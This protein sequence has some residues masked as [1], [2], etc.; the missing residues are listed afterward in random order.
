[1][2][3]AAV[4]QTRVEEVTLSEDRAHVVRRGKAM[5]PAGVGQLVVEGVAPVLADKTLRV[6]VAGARVGVVKVERRRELV[7]PEQKARTEVQALDAELEKLGR[8]AG[9]LAAQ[10]RRLETEVGLA[11]EG[12][13]RVLA[14]LAEDAARGDLPADA[15]RLAAAFE[16][17][18]KRARAAL[19]EARETSGDVVDTLARLRARRAAKGAERSETR[20]SVLVTVSA[21]R[22]GEADV[23]V[24]YVVPGACW[25]P[26]HTA[27][28]GERVRVETDA[29]VWQ[30]TG[31]AWEDVR[32][33]VS[34]ERPSLGTSPPRL[35]DDR[36]QV[37]RKAEVLR[38][39][40]RDQD[41]QTAG[42][43]GRAR[44]P[45]IDDGGEVRVIEAARR[46]TVPSDGRPHRVRLG[47]FDA[48]VTTSVVAMPEIAA[49][50][51]LRGVTS[52]AGTLPVLAGPVDLVRGGGFAGRAK[53]GFVA[54]GERFEL[55]WGPD[56]HL[57]VRRE[58]SAVDEEPGL[59]PSS[60]IGRRHEVRVTLS[61]LDSTPRS[62]EVVERVPVSEV[63]KVQIDVDEKHTSPR[64]RPDA[65]G[66]VRW[67]VELPPRGH[68]EIA[69][70]YVV[71]RHKDVAG[72]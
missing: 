27:I 11:E 17:G 55:G 46:A 68:A 57:R 63:E 43:G 16:A 38:V 4:A 34:T 24:E 62:V 59:L 12:A 19:V 54:P 20:A 49:A 48:D 67:T 36:L 39:E 15:S 72:V 53:V 13:R 69:L 35:A 50:A 65:D 31:E 52:N 25:R 37:Q 30:A 7:I 2:S 9:M 70:C 26:Q 29:C 41:V 23:T 66:F 56:P 71:R 61:N 47:A 51:V 14:E 8:E 64:A 33:R 6:T 44:V 28:L 32:L 58:A 1:M 40:A 22:A 18:E 45:G 5:L 42:L 10:V 60:W 3:A 21:D